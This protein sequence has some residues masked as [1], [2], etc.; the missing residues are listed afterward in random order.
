MKRLAPILAAA[1]LGTGCI[2]ASEPPPPPPCAPFVT[3]DWQFQLASGSVTTSC[4]TA[5]VSFVDVW[6]NGALVGSFDCL[7]PAGTVS[8]APGAN[9]MEVEG[10][11][12]AGAILYRDRFTLATAGCGAQAPVLAQPAEGRVTVAYA[13]TPVNQCFSPGPSFL[14]VKVHDDV[15]GVIAA[16]SAVA[17]EQYV[18]P[19]ALTFRLAAGDY[20]LLKTE[21]RVRLGTVPQTYGTVARDCTALPFSVAPATPSTLNV[22]LVDSSVSCP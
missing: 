13:F 6:S 14:W 4:S 9:A 3:V 19:N 20:T 17:P 10:L 7:G 1:V 18:C 11:D 2:V 15:A 16:D 5:G 21:E 8:L 22:A 12:A